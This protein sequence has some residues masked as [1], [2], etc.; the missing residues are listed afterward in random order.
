MGVLKPAT[1]MISLTNLTI[2]QNTRSFIDN[3][4]AHAVEAA[5]VKCAKSVIVSSARN[6]DESSLINTLTNLGYTVNVYN[7]NMYEISWEKAN[8]Q[9]KDKESNSQLRS[10][11]HGGSTKT[12]SARRQ[13]T[14]TKV[15]KG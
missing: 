5:A 6:I 3:D 10:E 2:Q 7:T 14:T 4:I 13:K 1:E 12:R 11:V 8:E 9:E 15:A